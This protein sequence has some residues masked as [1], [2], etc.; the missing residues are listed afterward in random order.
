MPTLKGTEASLSYAQCFSYL[1]SSSI[2][3]SI[4]HYIAGHFLDTSSVC[5]CV[6]VYAICY[7]MLLKNAYILFPIRIKNVMEIGEGGVE[8]WVL[9]WCRGK[10]QKTVLKQQLK[11]LKKEKRIKKVIN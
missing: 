7:F 8:S 3:V 4:F 6:C 11:K 9:G 10:R 5:V 1:V 2:S